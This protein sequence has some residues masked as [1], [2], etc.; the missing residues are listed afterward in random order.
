MFPRECDAGGYV[1]IISAASDNRR[2]L[3]DQ[4]VVQRTDAVVFRITGLEDGS[5]KIATQLG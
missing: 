1:G 2:T 3:V 4:A 5:R